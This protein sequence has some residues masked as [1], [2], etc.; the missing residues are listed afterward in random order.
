MSKRANR[1]DTFGDN[2]NKGG[3]SGQDN[4]RDSR[5]KGE[6]H[7]KVHK[8]ES[9]SASL[10]R[11]SRQG[12]LGSMASLLAGSSPVDRGAMDI[13]FSNGSHNQSP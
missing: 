13:M 11:E 4:L 9:L 1:F 6:K 8:V 10:V 12:P 3:N 2:N 7:G 5:N